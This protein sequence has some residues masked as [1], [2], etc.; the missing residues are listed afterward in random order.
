MKLNKKE[1]AELKQGNMSVNEYLHSFVR[2]SR[3]TPYD[4]N[5]DE[6]K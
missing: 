1:F 2:L 4:I 6:K 5:T 3:Y